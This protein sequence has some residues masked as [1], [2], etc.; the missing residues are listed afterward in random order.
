MKKN[1]LDELVNK[2]ETIKADWEKIRFILLIKNFAFNQKLNQIRKEKDENLREEK[3]EELSKHLKIPITSTYEY[4]TNKNIFLKDLEAQQNIYYVYDSMFGSKKVIDTDGI[5]IKF[6]PD[7]PD[8]Y[9]KKLIRQLRSTAAFLNSPSEIQQEFM[10]RRGT[11]TYHFL[12]NKKAKTKRSQHGSN[13][14]EDI[15]VYFVCEESL[16]Q[17]FTTTTGI[18]EEGEILVK[19]ALEFATENLGLDPYNDSEVKR[20]ERIYYEVCRRY[21]LPTLKDF[22]LFN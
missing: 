9:Y 17:V 6:D 5:Y 8:T 15:K 7:K 19:H 3:L 14:K 12:G 18:K 20:V 1:R 22:F 11:S 21:R 2:L 4:M 13:F 16:E 10:K